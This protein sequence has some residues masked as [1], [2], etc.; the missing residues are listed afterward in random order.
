[1]KR[2]FVDFAMGFTRVDTDASVGND[3]LQAHEIGFPDTEGL[4]TDPSCA[5]ER[6]SLVLC[7]QK[8]TYR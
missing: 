7:F 5:S 8:S 6:D 1:M 4:R 3:G 2:Y